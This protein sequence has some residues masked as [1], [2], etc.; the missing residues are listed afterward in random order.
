M[1][2]RNTTLDDMATVIGFS[3]T[4]RLSAWYGHGNTLFVPLQVEEGQV[5]VTLLGMPAATRLTQAYP[6]EHIYIPRITQYE[7]DV[8][9]HR[10]AKMLE[11]G[12]STREVS[13]HERMSERRVQQICRELETAGLILP[14]GGPKKPVEKGVGKKPGEKAS[15]KTP[16]RKPQGKRGS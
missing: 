8:Q 15:E 3:A 7:E 4:L 14:V 11:K 6:G 16:M 1:D 9:R 2:L 12:F 5:L 13:R 10:I